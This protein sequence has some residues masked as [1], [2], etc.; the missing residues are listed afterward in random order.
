MRR[1]GLIL[2]PAGI[3]LGLAAEQVGFGWNAPGHW[4]PD[5]VVGW[6]LI[7]C[8]LVAAER[9]PKSR[10]GALLTAAG[11][12]WFLGNFARL[13]NGTLAWLA[14]NGL[15]LYRGPLVHLLLAYPSGRLSS[16]LDRAAALAGYVA[17]VATPLCRTDAATVVLAALLIAISAREY[18]R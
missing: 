2:W 1:L 6:T 13:D 18:V 9:R 11:F 4:I 12:T 3:A 15:Y 14:T 5:L 7:G 10:T 17:A 8:G 16:R